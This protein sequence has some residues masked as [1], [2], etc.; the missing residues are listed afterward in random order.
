MI[1]ICL[2]LHGSNKEDGI[3]SLML[4]YMDGGSLQDIVEDGGCSDETTLANISVQALK[5]L[6][7][8]HEN[9][10]IHRDIKPGNCKLSTNYYYYWISCCTDF[11]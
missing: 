9:K 3:V 7:F 6:Q 2:I 5:G 10:Q 8:M 4:E 11:L 1:H